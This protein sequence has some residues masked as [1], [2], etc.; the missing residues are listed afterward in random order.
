MGVHLISLLFII[1]TY[2]VYVMDLTVPIPTTPYL[3]LTSCEK[4]TMA[5][6]RKQQNEKLMQ[7]SF[8]VRLTF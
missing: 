1:I 3:R 8:S 2:D 4:Y 7:R 6:D 5:L